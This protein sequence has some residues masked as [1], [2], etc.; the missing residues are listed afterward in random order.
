MERDP[1]MSVAF[2]VDERDTICPS[3]S[4]RTGATTYEYK[5]KLDNG[6]VMAVF[7]PNDK[8]SIKWEDRAGTNGVWTTR[9]DVPLV[10]TPARNIKLSLSRNWN[11]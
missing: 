6:D 2:T 9:A 10:S 3:I 4:L 8:V 7:Y 5:R 11:V 1:V